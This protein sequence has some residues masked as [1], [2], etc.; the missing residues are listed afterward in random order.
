MNRYRLL[1]KL[2]LIIAA[3]SFNS[4]T[5]CQKLGIRLGLNSTNLGEFEI[6]RQRFKNMFGINASLLIDLPNK[7]L[8]NIFSFETGLTFSTKG[9]KE[10]YTYNHLN[11][12][13]RTYISWTDL[14]IRKLNYLSVP[15]LINSDIKI[16]RVNLICKGGVYL[17]YGLSGQIEYKQIVTETEFV[18]FSK[19]YNVL[20]EKNEIDDYKRFDYGL[21]IETGVKIGH[22]E[23][24]FTAERGL[25]NIHISNYF[26]Y[27]K[28]YVTSYIFSCTYIIEFKK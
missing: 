4:V 28:D 19:K 12:S 7:P 15:F 2:I 1:I 9:T 11:M 27:K 6:P 22:F 16:N 17:S 21:S 18:I 3:F 10:L 23:I 13:H 5:Y 14:Y 26:T 8:L 25:N 24:S 20:W